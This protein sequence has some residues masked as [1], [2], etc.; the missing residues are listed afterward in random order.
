MDPESK[1]SPY[2]QVIEDYLAYRE[3]GL[4]EKAKE[5]FHEIYETKFSGYQ[6]K[7]QTLRILYGLLNDV[8][9]PSIQEQ[10]DILKKETCILASTLCTLQ[11]GLH[12]AQLKSLEGL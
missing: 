6:L 10:Y 9:I 7:M 4:E 3:L 5:V 11:E 2:N 12:N 1:K 8:S